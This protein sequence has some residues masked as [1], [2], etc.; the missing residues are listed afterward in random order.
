MSENGENNM[1]KEDDERNYEDKSVLPDTENTQSAASQSIP[2]EPTKFTV[3]IN[4]ILSGYVLFKGCDSS[5]LA[6][7]AMKDDNM[8]RL[9]DLV[10]KVPMP[11]GVEQE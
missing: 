9:R 11:P 8:E 1:D 4:T 5:L 2:M 10:T 3:E 6:I 7:Q